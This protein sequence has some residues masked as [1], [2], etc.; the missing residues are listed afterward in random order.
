MGYPADGRAGA[1]RAGRTAQVTRLAEPALHL[2]GAAIL[3]FRDTQRLR[4]ARQVSF[5]VRRTQATASIE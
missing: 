5:V 1:G 3:V 2:T 4:R